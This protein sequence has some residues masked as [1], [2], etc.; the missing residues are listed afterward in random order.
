MIRLDIL[1][2]SQFCNLTF[3]PLLECTSISVPDGLPDALHCA[4]N[5]RCLGFQCCADVD[6]KVTKRS[7]QVYLNVDPCNFVIFI[8]FG[9]W[10]L[11]ISIFTYEWGKQETYTLGTAI[12]I[13]YVIVK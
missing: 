5:S 6:F 13:R 7:L 1:S 9:E 3:I 4:I 12:E 10:F 11:D 2:K 8:G